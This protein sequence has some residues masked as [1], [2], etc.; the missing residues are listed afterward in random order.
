M[1][2]SA[3]KGTTSDK[4]LGKVRA[5]VWQHSEF[6][7]LVELE[8]LTLPLVH[9]VFFVSLGNG[10]LLVQEWFCYGILLCF[11]DTV[12]A[13]NGIWILVETFMLQGRKH[14]SLFLDY[15]AGGF[16]RKEG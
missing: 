8:I 4:G 7:L 9:I 12:V 1:F 5:E 16:N 3:D 6:S 2:P 13:V 10:C 15:D 11:P 14:H